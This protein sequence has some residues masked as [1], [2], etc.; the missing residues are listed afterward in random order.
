MSISTMNL[1]ESGFVQSQQLLYSSQ[2][3]RTS[4]NCDEGF[5]PLGGPLRRTLG[6]T[7]PP[8]SYIALI[9]LA[10]KSSPQ[11]MVTL[12]EVYQFIMANFPY[13]RQNRQKWQNTVRHNL[14]LN[15][16]FVKIPRRLLGI[17]G[18]G[19]YWTLHPSCADM[20]NNG[21]LLRRRRRFRDAN[22]RSPPKNEA[23]VKHVDSRHHFDLYG[24]TVL[25]SQNL[26]SPPRMYPVV[27][28]ARDVLESAVPEKMA[29]FRSVKPQ[30][31]DYYGV[32]CSPV[33]EA[34]NFLPSRQKQ[35]CDGFWVSLSSG[36][37]N[38]GLN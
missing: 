12:N 31:R 11:R 30:G 28:T 2:V 3:N 15:D 21:S 16:C 1:C 29:T 37:Q 33:M 32:Q 26:L 24:A 22:S 20:F 6:H 35:E 38:F 34:T 8:L 4:E 18:K 36:Y 19:N 13:Y 9:T 14:S 23:S 5:I 25:N 7:K 17:P 10:I 27:E